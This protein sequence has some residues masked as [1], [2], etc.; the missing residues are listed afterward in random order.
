MRLGHATPS[1]EG[2][3][4]VSES[5]SSRHPRSLSAVTWRNNER[6]V[7][8][9]ISNDRYRSLADDA[10]FHGRFS[11][12]G[13]L[14][15]DRCAF[16]GSRN[17]FYEHRDMRLDIDSMTY[18]ELLA[19]GERIGSVNTGL[20]EYSISK[21]LA[22]TI[23]HSSDQFQ[24]ESSC[25]ICLEEYKDMDEVGALKTCGH[26]Y[27]SPCIRKWLLMKNTCPICKSS[28]LTDDTS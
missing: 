19:L 1:E 13:F 28:V 11:S 4:V 27:H 25:V 24:D 17:M 18:E 16:Y 20:S 12:E 2:M 10:A 23:Y 8:S 26:K 21:S 6:N 3:Q 14:I 5:Y 15:V 7:R 22:E 9:R